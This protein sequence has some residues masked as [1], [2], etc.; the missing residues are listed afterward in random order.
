ME[1]LKLILLAH[2]KRYP[3]MQPTDAVKLIYQNEFGGG[4]LIRDEEAC[5]TYLRREYAATEKDPATPLQEDIGNGIVR[6]YLAA[7]AEEDL[8]ELGQRFIRSAAAHQG[9]LDRFQEKLAVLEEL[10]VQGVFAF[11]AASLAAYLKEYAAQGY[12]AVSHS[13]VYRQAYRP[14]YRVV[15]K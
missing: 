12:P 15:L 1:E 13:E 6:I 10:T 7:V 4:H 3:L 5:L 11:D 8:E 9:N 14:A 2:A